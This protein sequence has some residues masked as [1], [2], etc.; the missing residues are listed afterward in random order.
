MSPGRL[1]S[2]DRNERQRMWQGN[3]FLPLLEEEV[4]GD[5]LMEIP[6]EESYSIGL[7]EWWPE[8]IV[9]DCL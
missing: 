2:L 7:D 4:F 3:L 1:F 9:G 5:S 8:F 6:V